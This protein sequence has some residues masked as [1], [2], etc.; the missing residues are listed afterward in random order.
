MELCHGQSLILIKGFLQKLVHRLRGR[1]L[2]VAGGDGRLTMD[3]LAGEYVA[4]ELF[5]RNPGAVEIMRQKASGLRNIMQISC[6]SMEE[7]EF[8]MRYDGIYCR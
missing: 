4:V 6:S 3:F 1:A 7:Y 5:D 2:E 8:T